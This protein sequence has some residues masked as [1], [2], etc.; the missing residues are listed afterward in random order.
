MLKIVNI[1]TATLLHSSKKIFSKLCKNRERLEFHIIQFL[2]AIEKLKG[3]YIFIFL[4]SFSK[5]ISKPHHR[6][7]LIHQLEK[8]IVSGLLQVICSHN[9]NYLIRSMH[10]RFNFRHY[11]RK[12]L[13]NFDFRTWFVG[14]INYPSQF[15]IKYCLHFTYP[16]VLN[17]AFN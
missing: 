2:K 4:F 10:F 1:P 8:I 12:F 5:I 11:S 3:Q 17:I 16:I 13:H 15:S 7:L 14:I 6:T 9:L